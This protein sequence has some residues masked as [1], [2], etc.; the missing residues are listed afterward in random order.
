LNFLL[1]DLLFLTA[2]AHFSALTRSWK[3]IPSKWSNSCKNAL[4][5]YPE[6]SAVADRITALLKTNKYSSDVINTFH[7]INKDSV[8]KFLTVDNVKIIYVTQ[9]EDDYRLI[10]LN[11]ISKNFDNVHNF[12]HVKKD[13]LDLLTFYNKLDSINDI[14]KKLKKE[15][16]IQRL[17]WKQVKWLFWQFLREYF[18]KF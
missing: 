12:N 11:K 2:S 3:V 7:Y 8:D 10:A 15:L 13:Y 5:S 4:Q 9:E 6:N 18:L 16:Q 17:H 1:G 14:L